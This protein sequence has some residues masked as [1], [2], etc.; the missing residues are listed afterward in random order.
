MG[1][2][3]G[4]KNATPEERA[5]L[6]EFKT[7]NDMPAPPLGTQAQPGHCEWCNMN[8]GHKLEKHRRICL[9]MPYEIWLGRTRMTKAALMTGAAYPCP[10]C[11]T[12]Y[13]TTTGQASH[14][15]ACKRRREHFK[16]PLLTNTFQASNLELVL[17]KGM[18]LTEEEKERVRIAQARGAI[19]APWRTGISP[20]GKIKKHKKA[21]AIIRLC[22]SIGALSSD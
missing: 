11:G 6:R 22:R 21:R 10:H 12:K 18:E 16:L 4:S 19:G 13:T 5:R 8:L 1:P 14:Q 20:S 2:R 3:P 7:N 15:T 9:S 17:F